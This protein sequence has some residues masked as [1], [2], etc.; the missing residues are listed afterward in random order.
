MDS[1]KAQR[2]KLTLAALLTT[3]TAGFAL[4]LTALARTPHVLPEGTVLAGLDLGGLDENGVRA[5]LADAAVNAPTVTVRAGDRAW[6]V[7]AADYGW[8]PDV[9]R[10]VATLFDTGDGVSA[11]FA[12]PAPGED[13]RVFGKLDEGAARAALD[14]LVADLNTSPKDAAVAF[15]KTRYVVRPDVPGARADTAAAARAWAA[16]PDTGTVNV[17]LRA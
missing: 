13:A 8:T 5:A 16:S 17:S 2:T 15:D 12:R 9:D 11:R 3:L 1:K 7:D 6:T 14:T 10:T 4:G